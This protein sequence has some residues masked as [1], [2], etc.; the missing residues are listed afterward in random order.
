MNWN[1]INAPLIFAHRGAMGEA[2]ENTIASFQ[3]ALEQLCDVI[4]L[5]I[6]LTRDNE[7]VVC[8]D[9]SVDRT[10]D[11]SGLIRSM[12][13]DELQ[14]LDAGAW[15]H[16]KYA[17]QQIPLLSSVFELVPPEVGLNIELKRHYDGLLERLIAQ[18]RHYDRMDSLLFSSFDHKLLYQLK[19][20]AP[21]ARI[22]LVYDCKMRSPLPIIEQ[23]DKD[24]Y[25]IHPNYLMIDREDIAAVRNNGQQIIAW[26]CNE[27]GQIKQLFDMGIT[28]V[29]TDFI[30][31]ANS[32]VHP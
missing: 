28:G 8:H 1:M 10:T 31:R 11:G 20:M 14:R 24:V 15:F 21:E 29:I 3:L 9:E 2:P 26:T 16:P 30:S 32:S 19:E 4:E 5:D 25:S 18:I 12:T 17:G 13:L 6:H 22:S 7:I 27:P 23:F